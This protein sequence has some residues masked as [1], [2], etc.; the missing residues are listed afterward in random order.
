MHTINTNK[1]ENGQKVTKSGEYVNGTPRNLVIP[2]S[3]P[4]S[5]HHVPKNGNLVTP[6]I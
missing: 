1:Y 2:P 4:S 5:V 3:V 6:Q